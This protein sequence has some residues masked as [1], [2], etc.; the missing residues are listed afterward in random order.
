MTKSNTKTSGGSP[1][2]GPYLEDHLLYEEKSESMDD[3][4]NETEIG[5]VGREFSSIQ[6]GK[7]QK[8]RWSRKTKCPEELRNME[9]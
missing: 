8:K 5:E 6:E 4:N 1:E 3:G 7:T 2:E 9:R